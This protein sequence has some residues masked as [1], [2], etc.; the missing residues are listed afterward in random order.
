MDLNKIAN[1]LAVVLVLVYATWY[2][3][4]GTTSSSEDNYTQET[5]SIMEKDGFHE[6][7]Q[8]EMH[9]AIE[10]IATNDGWDITKFK[11]NTL[12][13]EKVNNENSIAVTIVFNNSSYSLT[14]ENKDLSTVL[15]NGLK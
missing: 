8:E 7:T 11:S 14:P 10:S 4:N 13:A 5:V 1:I 3:T 15:N 2:F 9:K 12:I 6:R